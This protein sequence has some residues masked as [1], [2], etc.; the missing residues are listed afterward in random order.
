MKNSAVG[1]RSAP[2]IVFGIDDGYVLPLCVVLQ[3]LAASSFTT[4]NIHV[5]VLHES[6]TAE[7]MRTIEFHANR[8]GLS[9]NLRP[10]SLPTY[11]AFGHVS[12]AAYLR[13]AIPA[14]I[15]EAETV[16][17]LDAD[18]LV[19]DDLGEL[20][21]W[22]LNGAP[23]AAVQD[24]EWPVLGVSDFL[25]GWKDLG[26]PPDRQYFNS[27]VMLLD[28]A[29]CRKSKLFDH[30]HQFLTDHADLIEYWDQDA[31]NWAADD[32]WVRLPYRWNAHAISPRI[33]VSDYL[34]RGEPAVP[35]HQLIADER[36]AAVLHFTGPYKPWMDE[37][38]EGWIKDAYRHFMDVV[39][40]SI[41]V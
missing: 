13:L 36:K 24:P 41:V 10:V 8:L 4:D 23:L 9:V 33:E 31:I 35:A 27:G 40:D 29:E 15:P 1:R 39:T 19:L 3:S 17:Y 18:L 28:L 20:L 5:I 11:P 37:Y 30:A 16:L 12:N 21:S 7:G 32:K 2:P 34:Y 14:L 25:L 26:L 6:L 22:S 38:P